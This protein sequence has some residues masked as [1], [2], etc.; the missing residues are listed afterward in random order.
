MCLLSTPSAWGADRGRGAENRD[1]GQQSKPL[2]DGP[3]LPIIRVVDVGEVVLRVDGAVGEP[4]L[5]INRMLGT[6]RKE[7]AIVVGLVI[8]CGRFEPA[9]QA[10]IGRDL[11]EIPFEQIGLLD[12]GVDRLVVVGP[13]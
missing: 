13:V 5:V 10:L 6:R 7:I 9:E 4:G 1:G 8:P 12:R 11:L 3:G 2:G